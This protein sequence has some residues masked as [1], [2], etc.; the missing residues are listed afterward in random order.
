MNFDNKTLTHDRGQP[1]RTLP[2]KRNASQIFYGWWVV[3]ASAFGLFWGIPISVYSF[4][5]FFK[6]LMQEFH[7]GRAAVSLAFTLKLLAGALCATPAG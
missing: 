5:V 7:V 6:P 3:L 2:A 4:S 1:L